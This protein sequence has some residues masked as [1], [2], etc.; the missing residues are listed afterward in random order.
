MKKIVIYSKKI[1]DVSNIK[2]DFFDV[3]KKYLDKALKENKLYTQQIKRKNCKN[4]NSKIN[5]IIF[6]SHKVDYTICNKCSHLN[7][8]YEDSNKFVN[9]I[10]LTEEGSNY[11][12]PYKKDFK[13]R[14]K[15][16]YTPKVIFLKKVLKK[17][18]SL[19]EIGCGAGHFI[20]ACEKMKIKATGFDVNRE[21]ISIGKNYLKK[22]K[23]ELVKEQN[24]YNLIKK[25]KD[26][27]LA[28]I[29]TLEHLQ[30]PNIILKHIK[31]SNIKYLY[32]VVPLFSFSSLVENVFN[33]VYPRQLSGSHTHLF[34]KE[35]LNYL[36]KKNNF[37]ILG[38]WWFGT[39]ISDLFRSMILNS[40]YYDTRFLKIYRKYFGDH[41]DDLQNVLD[42]KK[43][44]CEVHMV[45]KV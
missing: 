35:S 14:V 40:N 8:I 30:K 45:L 10:Y 17:K 11:A 39:D 4:C 32:I 37:K 24:I 33:N 43:I 12:L 15:N 36:V 31:K 22:N 1:S 7:G 13:L 9:K 42:R 6:K 19:I 16:I 44:C 27:V 2:K 18:F 5:K 34:T 38:E 20:K 3:N 25:S 29:S 26:D 28:M 23:V 41:I 21:L